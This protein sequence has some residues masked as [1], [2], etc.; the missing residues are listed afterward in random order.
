MTVRLR[1]VLWTTLVLSMSSSAAVAEDLNCNVGPLTKMYGA[2]SW[3]IYSCHDESRIVVVTAPGSLAS[4]FYFLVSLGSDRI[5]LQGEGT[6]RKDLT[7][8]AYKDLL[9]LSARD[10]SALIAETKEVVPPN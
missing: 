4:P 8:A 10:I 3:L 2:T 5:Y 1:A 7:D 9:S 6:G